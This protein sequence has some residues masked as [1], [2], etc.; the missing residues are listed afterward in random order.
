MQ[1]EIKANKLSLS[2]FEKHINDFIAKQTTSGNIMT[3]SGKQHAISK[4]SLDNS[5]E[6]IK[7]IK[8]KR[9]GRKY[10]KSNKR[11][12]QSRKRKIHNKRK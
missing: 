3:S 11:K 5:A 12:K 7:N 6:H 9:G 1:T 10:K 4:G 8:A 2:D